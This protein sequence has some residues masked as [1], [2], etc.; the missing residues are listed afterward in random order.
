MPRRT[1]CC[2]FWRLELLFW[3]VLWTSC[4][5]EMFGNMNKSNVRSPLGCWLAE[6][7]I[8]AFGVLL[9]AMTVITKLLI[10]LLWI[11]VSSLD[12]NTWTGY[13]ALSYWIHQMVLHSL[14]FKKKNNVTK[15][16][17]HD[18]NILAT[19]LFKH[20]LSHTHNVMYAAYVCFKRSVTEIL[21]F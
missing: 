13:I 20:T 4:T 19:G 21:H 2:H 8:E 15:T 16:L 11:Y 10:L 14:I 12:L 7:L 18:M 9:T 1:C 17:L 6:T 3:L 5:E